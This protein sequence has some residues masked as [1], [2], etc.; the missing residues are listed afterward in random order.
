MLPGSWIVPLARKAFRT[1]VVRIREVVFVHMDCP[2]TREQGRSFRDEVTLVLDIFSSTAGLAISSKLGVWK[3]DLRTRHVVSLQG[4]PLGANADFQ[5]R[6]LGYTGDLVD[7][8]SSA[9][10]RI[11]PRHRVQL[12]RCE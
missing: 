12:G 2:E 3:N 6:W 11:P 5:Q 1:K 7:P 8:R 4:L 9:G 10:D